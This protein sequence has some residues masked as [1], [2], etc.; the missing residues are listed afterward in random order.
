MA[1]VVK[2]RQSRVLTG[3][4]VEMAGNARQAHS[5]A[6]DAEALLIALKYA[7]S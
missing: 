7:K 1:L 6:M 3:C 2:A 4:A 5:I